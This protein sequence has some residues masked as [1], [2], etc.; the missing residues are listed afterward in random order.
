MAPLQGLV[1]AAVLLLGSV[2]SHTVALA[3]PAADKVDEVDSNALNA[4]SSNNR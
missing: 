2:A 1:L 4:S 3:A